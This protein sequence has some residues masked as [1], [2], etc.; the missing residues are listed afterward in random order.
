MLS[1]FTYSTELASNDLR[2]VWTL[3]LL[4]PWSQ[5]LGYGRNVQILSPSR[6]RH[7]NSRQNSGFG[8]G[9]YRS[10]FYCRS[11]RF[12]KSHSHLRSFLVFPSSIYVSAWSNRHC[13]YWWEAPFH[14][15]R[16]LLRKSPLNP[17][18][19]LLLVASSIK[20]LLSPIEGSCDQTFG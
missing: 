15:L 2:A 3:H 5:R 8:I 9:R 12:H 17:M 19:Q 10:S 6:C 13:C 7:C 16:I 11:L 1:H 14:R 4:K 18:F 20:Y